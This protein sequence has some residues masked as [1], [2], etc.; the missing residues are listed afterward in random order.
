MNT[1][2][3]TPPHQVYGTPD[4]P[5]PLVHDHPHQGHGHQGS[6]LPRVNL[7]QLVGSPTWVQH[8]QDGQPDQGINPR[9][10]FD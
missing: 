10:L 3:G 2:P 7:F 5:P 4:Q 6:P 8:A 1:P 9:K